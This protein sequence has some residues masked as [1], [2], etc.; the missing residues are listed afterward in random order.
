MNRSPGRKV[1]TDAFDVYLKISTY[2]FQSIALLQAAWVKQ[3]IHLEEM[4]PGKG[5]SQTLN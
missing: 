5:E 1:E 4:R 3:A 2:H